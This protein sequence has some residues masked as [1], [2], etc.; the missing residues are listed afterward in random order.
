MIKTLDQIN[1][2]FFEECVLT[3]SEPQPEPSGS[4][5][6]E[7]DKWVAETLA[8]LK[9]LSEAVQAAP[10][11]QAAPATPIVQAAPAVQ[12]APVTP[13]VQAAPAVK[14]RSA[15]VFEDAPDERHETITEASEIEE[16]AIDS[17]SIR[18]ARYSAEPEAFLFS[19]KVAKYPELYTDIPETS[20]NIPEPFIDIPNP[21]GAEE[22]GLNAAGLSGAAFDA[23]IDIPE[24]DIDVDVPG[25]EIPEATADVKKYLS[26]TEKDRKKRKAR[27]AADIVFY[28]VI[29]FILIAALIFSGRIDNNGFRIFHYKAFTVLTPSMEK[30]IPQGALVITKDVDPKTIEIGD[31]ITFIRD[32]NATVTHRVV[33]ILENYNGSSIRAF[34]TQGIANPDPD[35]DVVYEGNIIG[36]VKYSIPELGFTLTYIS[37]NIGLVFLVLGGIL[38]VMIAL[39]MVFQRTKKEKKGRKAAI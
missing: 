12:A 13:I 30:E 21:P 9:G 39:G 20:I 11:A 26:G 25:I 15:A 32:D 1:Q 22:R 37:D 33:N 4:I 6:D 36:V 34:E 38:V 27:R 3:E 14:T 28:A 17:W 10:A 23:M 35:P 29:A 24:T 16:S 7:T 8:S 19:D 31:D 5:E 18:G 2:E